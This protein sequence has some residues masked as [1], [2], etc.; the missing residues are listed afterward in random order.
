MMEKTVPDVLRFS[1]SG[2]INDFAQGNL[3]V[4]IGYNGDFNIANTRAQAA[5]NGVK[6]VALVPKE[7]VGV[8]IDTVVITKDA[9]NTDNALK[10]INWT[11]EPKVAAQNGNLVNY[12][13]GTNKA[14]AFM[15]AEIVDN[16]SIFPS[17]EA[18]KNS[19]VNTEKKPDTVKLGVRLWQQIKAKSHQ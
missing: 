8:W 13:P 4:G 18:L 7:G 5:K 15:K 9:K 17:E 2:Y 14:K 6:V 19:F 3:C 11:L 10:Y 12:A 16:D 1:S